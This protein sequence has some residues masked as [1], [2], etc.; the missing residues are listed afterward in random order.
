MHKY[1][2]RKML[3][4]IRIISIIIFTFFR[5]INCISMF[6]YITCKFSCSQTTARFCEQHEVSMYYERMWSIVIVLLLSKERIIFTMCSN[7]HRK[8]IKYVFIH[9]YVYVCD[10]FLQT[11]TPPGAH[12]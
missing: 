11:Q 9:S 1:V 5:V 3:K 12:N 6:L 10:I 4:R 8:K 7:S 2:L